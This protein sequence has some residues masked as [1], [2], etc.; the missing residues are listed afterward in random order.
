MRSAVN[1]ETV[2]PGAIRSILDD[3]EFVSGNLL[4]VDSKTSPKSISEKE[5]AKY[6]F[7]RTG[8]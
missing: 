6:G 4:D 7:E 2:D 3:L 1:R 8:I 5:L